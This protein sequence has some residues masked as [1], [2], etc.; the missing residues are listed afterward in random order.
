M[1]RA[2]QGGKRKCAHDSGAVGRGDEC[3]VLGEDSDSRRLGSSSIAGVCK[4]EHGDIDQRPRNKMNVDGRSELTGSANRGCEGDSNDKDDG[5]ANLTTA[6]YA[7]AAVRKINI[8]DDT[9][10][11]LA[12]DT[13]CRRPI[14]M[15]ERRKQSVDQQRWQQCRRRSVVLGGGQHPEDNRQRRRRRLDTIGSCSAAVVTD[16]CRASD[17]QSEGQGLCRK[18]DPS[19][20]AGRRL[21]KR[22]RGDRVDQYGD[23]LEPSDRSISTPRRNQTDQERIG[24]SCSRC[25]SCRKQ[26]GCRG[27]V[28]AGAGAARGKHRRCGAFL[29]PAPRNTIPRQRRPRNVAPGK[30]IVRESPENKRAD[31]VRRAEEMNWGRPKCNVTD[32]N[33]GKVANSGMGTD[34]WRGKDRSEMHGPLRKEEK[35]T[36]GRSGLDDHGLHRGTIEH[37][38]PLAES[39]ASGSVGEICPQPPRRPR[40]RS[41]EANRHHARHRSEGRE[42]GKTPMDVGGYDGTRDIPTTTRP[43]PPLVAAAREPVVSTPHPRRRVHVAVRMLHAS[44]LMCMFFLISNLYTFFD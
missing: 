26:G 31:G 13:N 30:N 33:K 11:G 22:G 19:R 37:A 23:L 35:K 12:S 27:T 34:I 8:N 21:E 29:L 9:R 20:E 24:R 1:E 7:A 15:Y 44:L 42:S 41:L 43:K 5:D 16:A 4:R 3:V 39:N 14:D 36:V 17:R 38:H 6:T 25:C 40:Q 18:E 2:L 32:I 28:G 10:M